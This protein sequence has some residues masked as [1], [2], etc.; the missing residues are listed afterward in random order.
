MH[1]GIGS[2]AAGGVKACSR[3]SARSGE[4]LVAMVRVTHHL[5]DSDDVPNEVGCCIGRR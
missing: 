3:Q 2:H 5:W 4:A 1:D